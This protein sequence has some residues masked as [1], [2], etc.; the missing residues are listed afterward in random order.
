MAYSFSVFMKWGRIG[1]IEGALAIISL[2]FS[3]FNEQTAI[4]TVI[5]A[6]LL[7][8]SSSDFRR[9]FSYI[10]L[11]F[12][13]INS[14][15]L[16]LAPGN[17]HRVELESLRWLP[18]FQDM[19][20]IEKLT[21]G[22][23]RVHQTVVMH[24]SIIFGV[25]CLLSYLLIEK[26]SS[27]SKASLFFKSLIIIH[28]LLMVFK[29]YK[30]TNFGASFYNEDYLNAQRWI[31]YSRYLSYLL[32]LLVILAVFYALSLAAIVNKTLVKPLVALLLG[33]ATIAMLSFSPTVFASWM[34]VLFVWEVVAAGVCLW[35]YYEI[36]PRD[37]QRDTMM[38][39]GLMAVAA[40]IF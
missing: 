9:P 19:P 21:F 29:H 35:I 40:V 5:S 23:D 39:L 27:K 15:V 10:Y 1:Y 8:A 26:Y 30:L 34:R 37:K 25:L 14:A 28:L 38:V 18:G 13:T 24:D 33:Y 4:F 31:S 3:C 2:F 22:F 16:L 20:L 7:V 11:A 36:F 12:A 17:Y 6:L 32:S